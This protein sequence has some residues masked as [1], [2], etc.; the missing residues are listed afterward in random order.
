METIT[1]PNPACLVLTPQT[2]AQDEQ[3][4]DL[5]THIAETLPRPQRKVYSCVSCKNDTYHSYR[6]C[7]RC[8]GW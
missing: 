8:L 2:L 5:L 4:Q 6:L 7:G 3:K 1:I